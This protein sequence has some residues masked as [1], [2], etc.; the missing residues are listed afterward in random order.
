MGPGGQNQKKKY[1]SRTFVRDVEHLGACCL[2]HLDA[3]D[4]RT[5]LHGLGIRSAMA[6]M[7]DPVSPGGKSV[8][9][10]GTVCV[11]CLSFVSPHSYR[12]H[13]RMLSAPT[14]PT[15]KTGIALRDLLSVRNSTFRSCM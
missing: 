14:M 8:A 10:N 12:L 1:H 15:G 5:K 6:V 2:M 9:R 7:A 13:A 11:I 4:I 3:H